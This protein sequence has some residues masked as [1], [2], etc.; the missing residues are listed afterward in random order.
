MLHASIRAIGPVLGGADQIHQSVLEAI[1]PTGTL[2]MYVGCPPELEMDI[3][4]ECSDQQPTSLASCPTFEASK[5]P[6]N[7][8]Y[9]ALA[10]L[11]RRWP[12]VICSA[13]PVVRMAALG[14]KAQWLTA[15]HP[16]NYGYGHGSPLAKLY[17]QRGKIV[18]L[19]SDLAHVTI[20]HYAENIAPIANKQLIYQQLPVMQNDQRIWIKMEDYDSDHGA[21]PWPRGFFAQVVEE[22]LATYQI[23]PLKVGSADSY[24]LDAKSLVDFAVAAFCNMAGQLQ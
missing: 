3:D 14:A 12:G 16:L 5:T 11:F 20:L 24:L 10:E 8:N 9:G 7:P 17:Q 23:L 19:G 2:M 13:N 6:A 21:C 18:L 22:Y 4:A 1:S 15:N